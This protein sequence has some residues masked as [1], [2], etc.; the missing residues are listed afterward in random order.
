MP[1]DTGLP[2]PDL[3]AAFRATYGYTPPVRMYGLHAFAQLLA[4]LQGDCSLVTADKDADAAGSGGGGGEAFVFPPAPG[5]VSSCNLVSRRA[6]RVPALLLASPLQ[7]LC[8]H[9]VTDRLAYWCWI[10]GN[11]G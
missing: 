6:L 2:L 5:A 1:A 8:A 4:K 7:L 11:W 10:E 3:F 9:L